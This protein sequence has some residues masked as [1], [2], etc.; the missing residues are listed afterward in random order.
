[1][2][3]IPRVLHYVFRNGE[4]DFA[5]ANPGALSITFVSRSAIAH[6]VPERVLFHCEFEPTGPWWELSRGL[7]TLVQ[8][9][10]TG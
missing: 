3:R 2:A 9:F 1:M 7:V 5:G 8:G 10:G 4:G 6:I